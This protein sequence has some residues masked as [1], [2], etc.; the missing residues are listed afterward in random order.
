MTG[1]HVTHNKMVDATDMLKEYKMVTDHHV[2]CHKMAAADP[3]GRDCR[4]VTIFL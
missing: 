1:Y 2:T 3:T 4:L